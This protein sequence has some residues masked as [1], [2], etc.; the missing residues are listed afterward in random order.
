MEPPPA[1]PRN[2]EFAFRLAKRIAGF[3][4]REID[5][6]T[7][8]FA[9]H[10]R[11]RHR[12]PPLDLILNA[13]QFGKFL[14]IEGRPGAVAEQHQPALRPGGENPRDRPR[15]AFEIALMGAGAAGIAEAD[16]PI[17]AGQ[18]AGAAG[19]AGEPPILAIEAVW[20][21]EGRDRPALHLAGE[22]MRRRNRE[23][24]RFQRFLNG[25]EM[26]LDGGGIEAT[27]ANPVDHVG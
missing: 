12:R 10:F 26:P 18:G 25:E 3:E 7:G 24:H 8:E 16:Q 13:D 27:G 2:I 6:E 23:I 11:D 22:E 20:D 15:G 9:R 17:T 5:I 21:D 1:P 19:K 4:G 14:D